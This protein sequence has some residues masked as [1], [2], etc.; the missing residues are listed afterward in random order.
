MES[1]EEIQPKHFG[2]GTTISIEG[3]TLTYYKTGENDLYMDFHSYLSD[4]KTQ[5]AA[6]VQKHLEKLIKHLFETKALKEGGRIL[7]M[8]DGCGKQYKSATSFF[9]L[10]LCWHQNIKS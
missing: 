1:N 4:D 10:L 9:T 3:Y 5:T 2:G 6:T 7:G 8:T